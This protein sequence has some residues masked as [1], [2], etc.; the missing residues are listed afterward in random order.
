MLSPL[1]TEPLKP[2]PLPAHSDFQFSLIP[3]S[4]L[5][6]Q[7]SALTFNSHRIHYDRDFARA[8][9]GHPD[10]LVHGPLTSLMLLETLGLNLDSKRQRIKKFSYRAT[11]PMYP[12]REALYKGAWEQE[13]SRVKLWG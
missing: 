6:F 5:L 2:L 4:T 13:Q 7:F 11:S 8:R 3:T 10:I 1:L 12:N 9:E